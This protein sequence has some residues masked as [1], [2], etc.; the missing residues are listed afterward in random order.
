MAEAVAMQRWEAVDLIIE[1]EFP[2]VGLDETDFLLR[3]VRQGLSCQAA[4][5][6][7]IAR[8]DQ[9]GR[10][11]SVLAAAC[12]RLRELEI[13]ADD[14][15]QGAG[16]AIKLKEQE[17]EN[18]SLRLKDK[19][20]FHAPAMSADFEHYKRLAYWDVHEATCLMLGK[21]PRHLTPT[22]LSGVP[23]GSPF[24][25]EFH[26]LTGFLTRAADMGSIGNK[27]RIEPSRLMAW[28]LETGINVPEGLT[29]AYPRPDA[30][31][32]QDHGDDDLQSSHAMPEGSL[33]RT[34]TDP[35]HADLEKQVHDLKKTL[36]A[37]RTANTTWRKK[38]R[39]MIYGLLH[40]GL[41]VHPRE[42]ASSVKQV[43]DFLDKVL[44]SAPDE[45]TIRRRIEDDDPIIEE[46]QKDMDDVA[47]KE[48][49]AKLRN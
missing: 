10:E 45:G 48:C 27:Q 40:A 25:A 9:V 41:P 6:A 37:E 8:G 2:S 34:K 38:T 19:E 20:L 14:D 32:R 4:V 5:Q 26:E 13:L 30:A 43:K 16:R 42:K 12:E 23:L 21:D 49:A 24:V 3:E 22:F 7:L 11:T 17:E 36:K 39:L 1:T 29:T 15:I 35:S 44:N 33:N 18:E 31:L 28:A 47:K 46:L